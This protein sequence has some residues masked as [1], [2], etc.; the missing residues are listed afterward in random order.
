M[1]EP[2]L[3]VVFGAGQVGRELAD[4]LSR[5]GVAVR[6]VSRQRPAVL[7][8]GVDWR[9]ADVTDPRAAADVAKGHR[10][11]TSA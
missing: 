8:A 2:D 7:P 10:S 6:S 3:H 4:Q 5:M 9:A 1:S 11:S